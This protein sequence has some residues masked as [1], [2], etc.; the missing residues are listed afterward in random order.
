MSN[1]VPSQKELPTQSE[2][3]GYSLLLG[4]NSEKSKIACLIM[5]TITTTTHE[6]M[7]K[8]NQNLNNVAIKQLFPLQEDRIAGKLYPRN[9]RPGISS[10]SLDIF[11]S[12]YSY[13]LFLIRYRYFRPGMKHPSGL[14][15][16]SLCILSSSAIL[17]A[18]SGS[19]SSSSAT[20]SSSS[21]RKIR[22]KMR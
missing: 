6:F 17:S 14:A 22:L 21:C 12:S 11:Q 9:Q 4:G 3:E 16:L 20:S 18:S 2:I 15:D 1:N 19:I 7:A 8:S 13:F 5:T 10:F